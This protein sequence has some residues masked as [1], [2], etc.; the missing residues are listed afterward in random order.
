M[1][2]LLLAITML[3]SMSF[4][5]EAQADCRCACVDG[6]AQNICSNSYDVKQY[7]YSACPIA[8]PRVRPIQPPIVHPQAWVIAYQEQVYNRNA[9]RY[10]FQTV[11]R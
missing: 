5:T 4:M 6:R 3:F 1:K 11:C 9:R 2:Y 7:C 8:P 10:E